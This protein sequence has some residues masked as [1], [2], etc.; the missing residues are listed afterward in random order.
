MSG[1]DP[2]EADKLEASA[3]EMGD[4][5]SEWRV[6]YHDVPVAKFLRI[7]A[8]D[9]GVD[10]TLVSEPDSADSSEFW[11]VEKVQA[12]LQRSGMLAPDKPKG[13]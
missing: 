6:S 13:D 4:E 12:A 7:E 5:P 1:L 9:D 3:R 11:F 10:W 2:R 8:S